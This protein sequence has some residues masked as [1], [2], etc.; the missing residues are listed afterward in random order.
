MSDT[1]QGEKLD[2]WLEQALASGIESL[3]N[4]ARGLQQDYD[5]VK[6][7]LTVKWSNGPVEGQINRLKTIK[8]QMY[9]RA[10]FSLLRKRVLAD[11][12]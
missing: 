3:K 1:R 6:S 9:G 8:R 2:K 4:F 7:A 5:A 11:T 12:G 10:G